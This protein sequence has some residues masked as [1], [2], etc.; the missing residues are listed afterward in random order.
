MAERNRNWSSTQEKS[1]R[2]YVG[3]EVADR[4]ASKVASLNV[5]PR[6][7]SVVELRP[8]DSADIHPFDVFRVGLDL[9][10]EVYYAAFL[11][12][13]LCVFVLPAEPLDLI[14]ASVFKMQVSWLIV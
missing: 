5:C 1:L 9:E 13:W 8:W 12:C 3:Y 6:R 7:S 4:S 11:S 2:S 14:H 10:E